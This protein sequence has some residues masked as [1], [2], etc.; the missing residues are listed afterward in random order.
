MK[1]LKLIYRRLAATAAI[2]AVVILGQAAIVQATPPRD[3]PPPIPGN[4][5]VEGQVPS[6]PP[7]TGA[8]IAI[9]GNGQSFSNLPI[10]VSGSCPKGLLV[11]IFKNGVFSGSTQC[12]NGSYSIQIDLFAGQNE[13][14]ARVFDDLGQPGPDSNKV[15]VNFN[16]GTPGA[17]IRVSLST[18]FA[19]RGAD[20]GSQLQW[21][22]TITGGAAPYAISVD[23]GDKSAP[24]LISQKNP[25]LFNLTHT[26][27]QPGIYNVIIKATD[28]K[29]D[30]AYLQLVGIANGV[31]T[32]SS[33]AAASSNKQIIKV[34]IWWP[35]IMFFILALSS[36]W[37]GKRHE[38]EIIKER[39]QQ[40][41]R[42]IK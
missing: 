9:P 28:S 14:I 29:G 22:I 36:F 15:T 5:G 24:D 37:L 40:G 1:Y 41:K 11:E 18:V 33:G 32:Q 13:L 19:K 7:T 38:V 20:P 26:Y 31:A 39:I 21:P 4:V 17:G 34:V 12:T 27:S 2:C 42:P 35:F 6:A 10:T 25:G 3:P 23:W 8:T 16:S 30:S